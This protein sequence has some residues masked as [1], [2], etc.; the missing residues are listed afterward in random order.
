MAIRVVKPDKEGYVAALIEAAE[1]IKLRAEE[2]VGDVDG[3]K[4][5]DISFSIR[6]SEV[7]DIVINKVFISGFKQGRKE[8]E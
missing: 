4:R 8:S 7:T 2:I 3:Q 5:I 1:E 6:P